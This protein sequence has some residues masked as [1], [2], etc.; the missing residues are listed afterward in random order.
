MANAGPRE[1]FSFESRFQSLPIGSYLRRGMAILTGNVNTSSRKHALPFLDALS[2]ADVDGLQDI[3]SR[4]SDGKAVTSWL[5]N[6]SRL[7]EPR[8]FPRTASL[9]FRARYELMADQK[10]LRCRK[11]RSDEVNKA[12]PSSSH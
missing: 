7:S 6:L 4:Q 11:L 9:P 8:T 3:P 1:R 5:W 2:N 10:L 12:E